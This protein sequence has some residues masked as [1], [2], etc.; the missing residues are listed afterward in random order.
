MTRLEQRLQ[1]IAKDKKDLEKKVAI[2]RKNNREKFLRLLVK[3]T[4]EK[5]KSS[6]SNENP[7]HIK[8][9]I[10]KVSS[11]LNE[12]EQIWFKNQLDE[13]LFNLDVKP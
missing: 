12:K 7:N 9:K 6:K 8:E 2:E 10:H 5:L 3:A 1:K 4:I 13:E 11:F